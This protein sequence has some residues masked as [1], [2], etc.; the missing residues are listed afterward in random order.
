MAS[1]L[2]VLNL[3]R[4]EFSVK[5][6]LLTTHQMIF[7]IFKDFK[8]DYLDIFVTVFQGGFR[9]KER[10]NYAKHSIIS[11]KCLFQIHGLQSGQFM[12]TLAYVDGNFVWALTYLVISWRPSISGLIVLKN[13]S[14]PSSKLKIGVSP[15]V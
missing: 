12:K 8:V 13:A 14:S 6:T 4:H 7:L 10:S 5:S 11:S 3:G 1:G 9:A 15:R 2:V